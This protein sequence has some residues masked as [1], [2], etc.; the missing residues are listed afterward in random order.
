VRI[1][2]GAG[3]RSQVVNSLYLLDR[4]ISTVSAAENRPLEGQAFAALLDR[5]VAMRFS[6]FLP[7]TEDLS[8]KWI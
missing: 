8:S 2:G 4:P 3:A 5:A 6:E 1:L 7:F